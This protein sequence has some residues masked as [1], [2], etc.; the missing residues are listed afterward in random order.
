MLTS[1]A[2][3]RRLALK[4]SAFAVGTAAFLVGVPAL[5]EAVMQPRPVTY[6][7]QGVGT[8]GGD[9]KFQM[10]LQGPLTTPAPSAAAVVTWK[11]GQPT[12]SATPLLAPSQVATTD[13]VVVQAT[14]IITGTPNPS[15]TETRAVG[16]TATPLAPI[17]PGATMTVPPIMITLTPKATGVMAVVPDDFV[18]QADP[19][20][21][22]T[23]PPW[24]TCSV[25]QGFESEATA[26]AALITVVSGTPSSTPSN[27]PST[28]PS[29]TPTTST[30]TPTPTRTTPRPTR[31][32]TEI[33]TVGPTKRASKTP[34]AGA[35]TGG[36]GDMGPDGRMFVLAGSLLIIAAG[37]GGLV[38]RRRGIS[39][40]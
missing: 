13:R 6:T 2:R 39:R 1:Q 14:A 30:P 36:G 10:D 34:K 7:C 23:A 26:A 38:M 11:I 3:R 12:G 28:T 37:A 22:T 32:K 18:L 40:S 25:K 16:A 29:T 17:T 15:P 31:T 9:Y 4:T 19:A 27:T 20:S 33:V 21:G 35:D 24:Y 8:Q 5:A